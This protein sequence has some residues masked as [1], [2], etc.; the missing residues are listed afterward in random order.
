LYIH[1]FNGGAMLSLS[2][3]T[4]IIITMIIWWR[5]VIREATW[6]GYHTTLVQKGLKIGV[7]LFIISEVMFF[8]AFF[9]GIFS[10]KFSSNSSNWI[11][12][13]SKRD[14]TF[15]SLW[16]SFIKYRIIIMIRS[17]TNLKS[18]RYKI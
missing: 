18:P 5:D 14:Y 4:L 12:L 1:F 8:F 13:S 15:K 10:F 16:D 11:F 2:G 17:Y 6:S 9:L 7:I 3:L